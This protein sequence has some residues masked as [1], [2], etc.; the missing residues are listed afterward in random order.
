M[1]E[2]LLRPA[3]IFPILAALVLLTILLAPEEPEGE[4]TSRLTSFSHAPGGAR[5]LYDVSWRLGWPVARRTTAL[6]GALDTGAVYLLLDGSEPLTASEV[7][8]LLAAVRGGA[9]A[10]VVPRGGSGLADSLGVVRLPYQFTPLRATRR[11]SAPDSAPAARDT[12]AASD[13]DMAQSDDEDAIAGG[14][15]DARAAVRA[16]GAERSDSSTREAAEYVRSALRIKRPLPRDTVV[17][18]EAH[19]VTTDASGFPERLTRPSILGIPFGR[20]RVVAVADPDF[21]RNRELR[22]GGAAVLAVRL[23][24]WLSRGGRR[25]LVFDEYHQGF[26]RHADVSGWVARTLVGTAP[27]R[28]VAQLAVALVL[29]WLAVAVRPVSPRSR[30][31]VERRSPFEHVGALARAYEQ[32]GA[33]RLAGRRLVRGLR[34]RHAVGSARAESEAGF[35]DRVAARFPALAP[36]VRRLKRAAEAKLPPAEFVEV[37]EAVERIDEALTR[38]DPG[39]GTRD[40]GPGARSSVAKHG[41]E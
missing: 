2:R 3:V 16:R 7:A 15:I 22:K 26:G 21:L 20:G 34:R 33:T 35:L 28:V 38:R 41:S 9:G 6:R 12:A 19:S 17:F 10:L 11:D 40:P 5:G 14:G 39:P 24:E 1:L 8:S 23:V 18:Q 31:R 36:D 27:G 29:L 25:P 37:G 13:A 4:R 30:A 32:V